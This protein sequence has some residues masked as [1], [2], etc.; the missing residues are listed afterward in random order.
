MP[1]KDMEREYLMTAS[2]IKDEPAAFEYIINLIYQRCGI[3]LHEGKQ[4]LIR[5][6]LGK[7]I[8]HHGFH[9]LPDYCDFLQHSADE[10]EMTQVVDA[11]TTNFTHFLRE[12]DHFKFLVNQAL[13]SL[14]LGSQKR[15]KVWSA[16]CATGEEPYSIGFYLSEFFPPT[17]GWD[18]SILATDISTKALNKAMQGVYPDDK[19]DSLP[20]DWLRKYFKKG[21]NAWSGYCKVKPVVAERISFRQLNLLGSMDINDSFAVIFCR[22]V[23]IYFDR[24]TQ[25]KLVRQLTRFLVPNGYLLVGHAESLN[26]LNVPLK[27]L[28]PSI[29][30]KIER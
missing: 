21:V 5:A 13:P 8:R 10:D 29:Y 23:M 27:C 11:L 18:W 4:E 14:G 30:Q 24:P 7:R 15:F 22:N 28:K 20:K 26:G 1:I 17:A 16:A 19:M 25:E 2:K 6:R 12:E 9:S 3:R